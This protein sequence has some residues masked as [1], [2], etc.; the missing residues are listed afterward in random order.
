MRAGVGIQSP[1]NAWINT[2]VANADIWIYSIQPQLTQ[3]KNLS[4]MLPRWRLQSLHQAGDGPKFWDEGNWSMSPEQEPQCLQCQLCRFLWGA[5]SELASVSFLQGR[6]AISGLKNWWS[7]EC[8]ILEMLC[9][10]F[11]WSCQRQKNH[12]CN[13]SDFCAQ[14]CTKVV[15]TVRSLVFFLERVDLIFMRGNIF[16]AG[17][18]Q[19]KQARPYW[20]PRTSETLTKMW[21]SFSLG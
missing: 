15:L 12:S 8:R 13:K 19:T 21:L 7:K 10:R 17:I 9:L 6:F 2:A 14:E 20:Q 4:Y 5:Q 18:H 3:Q 16:L 11:L 1:I